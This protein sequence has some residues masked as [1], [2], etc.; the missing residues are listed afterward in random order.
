MFEKILTSCAD[1]QGGGV[2]IASGT[3]AFDASQIYSNFAKRVSARL[4]ETFQRAPAVKAPLEL[5][6]LEANCAFV[7]LWQDVSL[8]PRLKP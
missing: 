7:P 2:Y 1:F 6:D 3:V 5:P 8:G 4:L